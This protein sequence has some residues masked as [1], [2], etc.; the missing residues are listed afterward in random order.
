M[1][2]KEIFKLTQKKAKEEFY[3]LE[4]CKKERDNSFHVINYLIVYKVSYERY[5]RRLPF[6]WSHL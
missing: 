3:K 1:D 2:R 6:V 4:T 5:M